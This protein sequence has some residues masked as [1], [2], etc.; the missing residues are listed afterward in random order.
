MTEQTLENALEA[1]ELI[2]QEDRDLGFG[3]VVT[4]RSRQ[5][6]LNADGTFNVG[7]KGLP[8]LSSRNLYHTLL[9]MSWT[10]FL[11]L[12]LLLY[13]LSN[14]A[15][16][17]M[18]ASFGTTGLVDTSAEPVGNILLTGFFFSVQTFAT[19]GYGTIHPVG[20]VPN[21]LV[22]IESYYSLIAQALI[23]GVVFARFARPTA[24]ILFS[25]VSV[26]APYRGIEGL[27]FRMV[28]GRSN[29][30]I[31]VKVQVLFARFVEEDGKSVRRFDFLEL[32]RNRVTFFPLAWTVVHPI[33]DESPM[34]G[35]KQQ[36]LERMDAELLVLISAIDETF[37][38]EVHTRTSYKPYDIRCG[39]KFVSIYNEVEDGGNISI[40]IR[41]L[42]EIERAE[43]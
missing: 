25:D 9:S 2:E 13:F 3:A 26:I 18:Y 38:Q 5:R 16:G 29:Q 6:L 37:S 42:S 12:V 7:R 43:V 8:L 15:F 40:D 31:E 35:L 39:H 28:N 22:T 36:D 10:K 20:F 11:L 21:M 24:K 32:E 1:E 41:R 33:D 19:I 27:M 17:L 14:I 30:L 23:T 34:K 4:G